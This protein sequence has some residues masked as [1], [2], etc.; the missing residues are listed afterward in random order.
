[1]NA[2]LNLSELDGQNV[3]LLPSRTL[4]S[5][6][7]QGVSGS[8]ENAAGSVSNNTVFGTLGTTSGQVFTGGGVG[9]FGDF[10]SAFF[11]GKK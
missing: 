9:N 2:A 8:A 5:V 4:L 1:M 10:F 3:E 6:F 11:S 7:I